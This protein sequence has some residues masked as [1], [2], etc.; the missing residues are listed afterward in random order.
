[1]DG[2][3]GGV[4][5]IKHEFMGGT[6][7]DDAARELCAAANRDGQ[8]HEGTFND[9][10]IVAMP[11]DAPEI[12]VRLYHAA[13]ELRAAEYRES[14]QGKQAAREAEERRAHAQSEVTRLLRSLDSLDWATHHAPLRWWREFTEHADHVGVTFHRSYV[15]GQFH[16]H[17]YVTGVNCGRDFNKADPNNVARWIVGQ[18]LEMTEKVG[19]PHP[20]SG[21]FITEWL[22]ANRS[23]A[24]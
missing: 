17:G 21:K 9:I 22:D 15:L 6:R 2:K 20:V 13:S 24:A 8:L 16:G 11:G 12:V 18:C 4:S 1:M 7:I 14:P 19:S 5:N 3:R 10:A 23:E